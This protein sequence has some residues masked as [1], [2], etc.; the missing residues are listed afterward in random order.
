MQSVTQTLASEGGLTRIL[1]LMKEDLQ[2]CEREVQYDIFKSTLL[3]FLETISYPAVVSS[4]LLENSVGTIYNTIYGSGGQYAL[5]IFKTI[6]GIA[7]DIALPDLEP[8]MAAFTHT[9]NLNGTAPLIQD[10]QELAQ[11]F[12]AL[13][14]GKEDRQ[15]LSWINARKWLDRAGKRLGI[16]KSAPER[17]ADKAQFQFEIDGPGRLS[18]DGPRHDNDSEDIGEIQILPTFQEITCTRSPYLPVLDPTHWHLQGI[19]GLLDRNFRLYRE[20]VLGPIE[21]DIKRQLDRQSKTHTAPA[22]GMDSDIRMHTYPGCVINRLHCD[23]FEGLVVTITFD[24][25]KNLANMSSRNREGWWTSKKRLQRDAMVCILDPAGHLIFGTVAEMKDDKDDAPNSIFQDFATDPYRARV[26][27][28][29]A[30][31][32][33]AAV[34]ADYFADTTSRAFTLLEFPGILLQAFQPTLSAIQSMF[35][36]Q[37][38]PFSDVIASVGEA[39]ELEPPTYAQQRGFR[40]NISCLSTTGKQLSLDP[41]GDCDIKDLVANSTLDNKQAEALVHALCCQLALCQGPPGTGKSYTG[42]ALV[43]A[44]LANKRVAKL[45][46]I[47]TVTYTNHA[48]DQFLEHCLDSGVR[49]VIRIGGR[50]K[51]ERL[52]DLNLRVVSKEVDRTQVDRSESWDRIKALKAVASYVNEKIADLQPSG[53][54]EALKKYLLRSYPHQHNQLWGVDEDG[55]QMYYFHSEFIIQTWLQGYSAANRARY[56]RRSVEQLLETSA[57]VWE[58]SKV[59]RQSLYEFW[60]QDKRE[61]RKQMFLSALA[62]YRESKNDYSAAREEIDLRCLVEADIIGITTSGL[63]RNLKLLQRLPIKVVL[64]E[65]A[66]EVLEA[67]TL[68]ALLPSVEHAIFIGDHF[69]L[70]PQINNFDLSSENSRGKRY[71]LDLSLFER[72]VSP[73]VGIPGPKLPLSTLETQRRMHPSI[74]ALIRPLYPNLEDATKV[75]MY[76]EVAGMRKRLFW[77]NHKFLEAGA[78]TDELVATSK[79]NEFEVEFCA[80][81]VAH[82]LA[83]GVYQSQ[84]IAVITPYLGQLFKLRQRLSKQYEILSDDRDLEALASADLIPSDPLPAGPATPKEASTLL[85]ALKVATVDNFQGEEAKVVIVSLVRSNRQQKCGFLKTY[86]RINVLL[87]RAMH[88]MY[89]IGNTETSVGVPMWAQVIDLLKDQDNVGESLTLCCPRHPDIPIMVSEPDHFQ[90]LSPEGGCNLRCDRRL[91]CGHACP[92]KCHS[93]LK[94]DNVVCLEP[95]SRP[96]KGCDHICRKA[97]GEKCDP[98]CQENLNDINFELPCGHVVQNM[99]CWEYQDRDSYKCSV[100]VERTVPDCLHK[101]KLPCHEDVESKDFQCPTQCKGLLGCGHECKLSCYMCNTWYDKKHGNCTDKCNRPYAN[102]SHTCQATCHPDTPCGLCEKPCEVACSHSRCPLKCGVPCVPCAQE[103]CSSLCPHSTCMMPCA[104][105]CDRVPCSKRCP[106]KLVCGHQCPSLCGET[107]PDVCFCQQCAEAPIKSMVVDFIEMKTYAEAELDNDPIIIP[108]CGHALLMS[109][110]DGSMDMASVYD[111]D[112]NGNVKGLKASEPFSTKKLKDLPRCPNCRGSLRELNRYGRL[113][114]RVLLDESTKR[115]VTA[116]GTAFGPLAERLHKAQ[117]AL[118]EDEERSKKLSLSMSLTF[119]GSRGSQFNLINA[120]TKDCSKYFEIKATRLAI[121]Q[122]FAKV[123]R[124]ETPFARLWQLVEVAR[125]RSGRRDPVDL[126]SPVSLVAFHIMALGL[127]LRCDVGLLASVLNELGKL[128]TGPIGLHIKVDLAENLKDCNNFINEALNVKDYERAV[129]G[130]TFY[131]RYAA[132]QLSYLADPAQSQA[133]RAHAETHIKDA[134]SLCNTHKGKLLSLVSDIKDAERALRGGTFV[135]VV[136]SEERR[137]VLAAMAKEFRGTGH[138]YTCANGH[139]FTIGEC[140]MPMQLA[141]CPQCGAAI[142]GQDHRPT[143]GV[144]RADD[145]ERELAGMSL[146]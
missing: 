12:E 18:K 36:R 79:S 74:S 52:K 10:F 137:S 35:K 75:Q 17:A 22:K 51:S 3:P 96:K 98:K 7:E 55:F 63:A 23:P 54:A 4:A 49:K 40:F 32:K 108:K 120:L 136:T 83:Q 127:L 130:H 19:E 77:L 28:S 146:N 109:S 101:I 124:D 25:P 65:E 103:K 87:S 107:C 20:D 70:K 60:M 39:R 34:L 114:R 123:H 117:K 116:S 125:R 45:G 145:M 111:M 61:S 42:V 47:L 100:R 71:S 142:G 62:S 82:L 86:N 73:P 122:Y 64:I 33:D 69:Q 9:I 24:Q 31:P 141:R 102:C 118:A 131:V 15:E 88:G 58:M 132:I 76:P 59:E 115:F 72:L 119:N 27:I 46:P 48:D 16:G 133:L 13:L 93:D 95:C 29:P 121:A 30:E 84:D 139:P 14:S 143:E 41:K 11:I 90:Q 128:K 50:C 1:Q 44:L 129:E 67:H 37:D 105:P 135:T 85:N 80:C 66:G 6:A 110:M 112:P 68:T 78:E 26:T 99:K 38:V 89:L 43:R 8:T 21:G 106:E 92:F 140:G 134:D 81:L 113:V 97:C 2:A 144:A 138:W 5:K 57:D 94:H 91:K 56:L 104:A 126:Q 53:P